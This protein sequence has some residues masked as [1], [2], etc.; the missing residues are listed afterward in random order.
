MTNFA[1][2]E[3]KRIG[4]GFFVRSHES[5]Q[6]LGYCQIFASEMASRDRKK[7]YLDKVL[8]VLGIH[9]SCFSSISMH[10]GGPSRNGT[11]RGKRSS[12]RVASDADTEADRLLLDRSTRSFGKRRKMYYRQR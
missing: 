5:G 8:P 12:R 4:K 2:L 3:L 1:A 10:G 9:L 7:S 6:L 11:Y